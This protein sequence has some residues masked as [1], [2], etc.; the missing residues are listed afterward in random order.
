MQLSHYTRV[1]LYHPPPSTWTPPPWTL[2]GLRFPRDP[3]T[4][5]G[6]D[7]GLFEKS[8]RPSRRGGL[9]YGLF[10]KSNR[11]SK[12]VESLV[13]PLKHTLFAYS[14]RFWRVSWNL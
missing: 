3:P 7:L 13:N 12:R 9:D 5:G 4:G 10:R 14:L 6:L 2:D 1:T 8:N 11:P